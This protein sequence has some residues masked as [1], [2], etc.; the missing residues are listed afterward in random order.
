MKCE[1]LWGAS[2]SSED[3]LH[4]LCQ[5]PFKPHDIGKRVIL[6]NIS[7]NV[8]CAAVRQRREASVGA[9]IHRSRVS[10]AP[11]LS[12]TSLGVDA[13]TEDAMIWGVEGRK[14]LWEGL[15]T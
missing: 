10:P 1:Y 9:S 5:R 15:S 6:E 4:G 7:G 2:R 3:A 14:E 12:G 8:V 13:E 11:R